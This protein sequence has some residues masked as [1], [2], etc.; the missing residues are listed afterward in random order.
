MSSSFCCS[1]LPHTTKRA[2]YFRTQP[3]SSHFLLISNLKCKTL[4][5]SGLSTLSQHSI[6]YSVAFSEFIAA[7]H[8]LFFGS[9]QCFGHLG[10]IFVTYAFQCVDGKTHRNLPF[11]SWVSWLGRF[12]FEPFI[13]R[14]RSFIYASYWISVF[15]AE[16]LSPLSLV[17]S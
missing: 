2:L 15:A 5:F 14:L 7:F 11:T 16:G 4:S 8:S 12:L 10:F 13:S 17:T 3:F 1:W 6:F 9:C